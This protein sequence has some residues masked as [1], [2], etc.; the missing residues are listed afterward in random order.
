M[1]RS[2]YQGRFDRETKEDREIAER[3]MKQAGIFYLKD[4]LITRLSGGE[5]QRVIVARALAQEP[6]LLALDEPTS[7]LDIHHQIRILSLIRSLSRKNNLTV[8]AVLHDINHALEY[9]DFLFLLDEGTIYKTGCPEEVITPRVMKEIYGLDV[10]IAK[11][12][13]TGKPFLIPEY[14]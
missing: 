8:L 4:K 13:Y 2:P 1:G 10:Q 12:P 14:E 5:G 3:A 9:C 7:H 6:E 11:N